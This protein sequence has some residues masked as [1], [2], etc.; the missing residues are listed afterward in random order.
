MRT[1]ATMVAIKMRR[2]A[3]MA[4]IDA[5]GSEEGEG[6]DAGTGG[7]LFVCV[8]KQNGL[9]IKHVSIECRV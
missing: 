3:Q 2:Q 6:L 8:V 9:D 7:F 4:V 1:K 5:S